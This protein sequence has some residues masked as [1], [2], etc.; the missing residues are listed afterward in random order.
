MELKGRKVKDTNDHSENM[1]T[2]QVIGEQVILAAMKNSVVFFDNGN[3]NQGCICIC[4]IKKP[5]SLF[6]KYVP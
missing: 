3:N 2:N 1:N 6:F 4:T 5:F